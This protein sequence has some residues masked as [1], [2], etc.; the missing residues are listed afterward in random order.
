MHGSELDV[1]V[2]DPAGDE[3]VELL[4]DDGTGDA[5]VGREPLEIPDLP[6]RVVRHPEGTDRALPD[7]LGQCGDR[8]LGRRG[9]VRLV[10]VVQVDVVDLQT[11]QGRL[12]RQPQTGA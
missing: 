5:F 2:L 6:R 1:L 7:Q 12:E 4:A 8:L 11:L 9:T 10:Q 3:V